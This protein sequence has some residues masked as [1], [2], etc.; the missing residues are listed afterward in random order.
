MERNR[1]L[2][3]VSKRI[4]SYIEDRDIFHSTLY[5]VPD[6]AELLSISRA[7]DIELFTQHFDFVSDFLTALERIINNDNR[8]RARRI[9]QRSSRHV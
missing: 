8:K 1:T 9:R 4:M 2:V 7:E 5:A 6:I 3:T